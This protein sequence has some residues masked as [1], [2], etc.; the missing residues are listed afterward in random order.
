VNTVKVEMINCGQS[1]IIEKDV[2]RLIARA[3]RAGRLRATTDAF[4]AVRDSDVSLICVGT[5]SDENGGLS[6][7]YIRNCARDIGRTLKN[8]DAYHVVAVRSTVLPGTLEAEVI[9]ALEES[10]GKKVGKELGVCSNPEFLREGS[11]VSDFYNPP[12]TLIGEWDT[13]SGK[14]LAG[15]YEHL[16]APTVRTSVRTA[17]MVKYVSN[18]FHALK[19]SFANEIGNFCQKVGVEDSHEVMRIF[20]LDTKLNIST[21]YLKPGFAFGGSCLP[22]D[23]RALLHRA[24]HE[25]VEMP[26][27]QAIL[28]SNERQARRGVEMVIKTGKKRIGVLGLSFKAGTDDLR[29]S[30]LVFLVYILFGF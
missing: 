5:P 1:P 9:P 11:A 24:R 3:V 6:L 30:P 22:K 16:E 21:A 18:A 13:R 19:I 27:L 8:H 26:V 23:L 10:S 20:A 29:E 15:L 17:E 2:D 28:N 14:V 12:F 7:R 4:D 25:D